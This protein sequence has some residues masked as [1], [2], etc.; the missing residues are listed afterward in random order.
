MDKYQE[1]YNK[2]KTI[3]WKLSNMKPLK[4]HFDPMITL[5]ELVDKATP[6]KPIAE[7]MPDFT[8]D[9]AIQLVC[10]RCKQPIV[11]VWSLS[12]YQP[13]YCHCCGQALGWNKE[14]EDYD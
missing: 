2:L 6:K 5:H 12:E 14:E 10:P 13:Q 7:A 8:A 1:A 3:I 4:K 9:M 11:N